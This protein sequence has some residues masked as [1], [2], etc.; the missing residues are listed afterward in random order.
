MKPNLP[1]SRAF[2]VATVVL[3]SAMPPAF[4]S[5]RAAET[6]KVV[7]SE[8]VAASSGGLRDIDGD[9]S[10]WIELANLGSRA[11][12]LD[13]WYLT[14][15]PERLPKWRIPAVEIEAGGFLVIFA[16]GK[17]RTDPRRELHASFRLDAGGGYLALVEPDGATIAHEMSP[18]Y[19]PQRAGFSYGFGIETLGGPIISKESTAR[20]HVPTSDALGTR[21]TG[22]REDEPFDDSA[23]AGWIEGSLAAGFDAG[24]AP[25]TPIIYYS[26]DDASDP[27]SSI[28]LSGHGFDGVVTT[29]REMS[30]QGADSKPRYT[31]EGGGRSGATTDRALD[32]GLRG[33]GGLVSVPLAA[34]GAFDSATRNDAVTISLWTFGSSDQPA[35]DVVFWGS[36]SSNGTGT[37]S[38]NAHV[39]WS[40]QVIYFDT[41][42]CCDGTQRISKPESDATRWRGEWNHYAF[43]KNGDEKEIWQNGELFATGTNTA[44][45]TPIRGFFIGGALN[46]GEWSYGGKIDDF[47]VWDRALNPV[48][49]ASLALGASPLALSSITP[50]VGTNLAQEMLGKRTSAYLRIPFEWPEAFGAGGAGNGGAGD[51]SSSGV[52]L[53]RM[54]YND[55][56]AAWI[57]GGELVRRN[58][59]DPLR[60]DSRSLAARP[61][62][63]SATFEDAILLAPREPE[64]RT[65]HVFAIHGLNQSAASPDFLVLPELRA[66]RLHPDLYLSPPTPGRPNGPGLA[67]FVADTKF[68]VDRGLFS[69]PFSVEITTATEGAEIYFTLD[70]S[71]PEPGSP[72]SD[73]YTGPIDVATTTTL[74]AKAFKN[75]LEPTDVD[76]QS[77][78]FPAEV[79][80]QPARPPGVPSTWSGG[81]RADY[82]V[83]PDIVEN[84][85]PGYSFEDALL[86]LPSV[87]IVMDPDDLFGPERGIYYHS[88]SRSERAGSFELFHPDGSDGFGINA[89]IRIHGYTSRDHNFTPKHSF[90]IVFKGEFGPTKLERDVFPDSSVARFDQ[91]VLRGMSTDS[92]PVTDGWP[93]PIPGVPRWFREKAQYLREQWM[94]DS[95]LAMG[96]LSCHGR[97][98]HVYLNGLYWGLY[99]LTERPTDSFLAEHLGGEREEYDVLKD[100]AELQSGEGNAWSELI[101]RA[102][103]G[104]ASAAPYQSIQGNNPDGTPNRN[105][106]NY[107][108]VDDHID[109]MIV[110][111]FAGADD[112]PNHNWW[113][114]RRRG[115]ESLG[116]KFFAWDQEISNIS[117]EQTQTSWGQRFEEV[118]APNSPAFLYARLRLNPEWRQRFVD[119][120]EKHLFAGG[121]LT[122]ENCDARW[123]ERAR[124]IDHAIV[125]ESARWGDARRAEPYRRE[126]EWLAEQNWMR[127][128]YWREN[129]AHAVE[130]FRR[131]GLYSAIDAPIFNQHG[132]EIE[133]G[134]E[135]SVTAARGTIYYAL[136]GD[137]PREP[138]GAV[139]AAAV[140]YA[141]PLTL[142]GTT[143]VK[144]RAF[145][146]GRWSGLVEALFH[147]DLPLRVTEIH[148]HPEDDPTESDFGAEDFEFL[149]VANTGR[150]PLDLRGVR[151]EG[152][153]DFDFSAAR[154]RTLAPS[155][156]AV[157]VRDPIAFSRQ[158][159]AT[160]LAAVIGTYSGKLDDAGERIRMVGPA[161]EVIQDFRYSDSWYPETDGFGPS[162]VIRDL[163]AGPATWGDEAGWQPSRFRGGSPGWDEN[164]DAG[165]SRLPSDIDRDGRVTITDAIGLLG[166]LFQGAN[167][168]LPC[169]S[170]FDAGGNQTILDANGDARVDLSDA[171]TILGYLFLGGPAPVLG[172]S[173][174]SIAGCSDDCGA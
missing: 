43:V 98:V 52:F 107:L 32:F 121:A 171:V 13:G 165:G 133:P 28:D 96:Q 132:G 160:G 86:S 122:P 137:D 22:A 106:P 130:R 54:K 69:E 147:F 73:L 159:D 136:G 153:V 143:L 111:I 37:R 145:D 2:L 11:V 63:L 36:S 109:Y 166:L 152:A 173:C 42:G 126:V 24:P 116:F 58:A 25:S 40:D 9:T 26:F 172:E 129:H 78:I 131:V 1:T 77:Y 118:S 101:S 34:R 84:T 53:L 149:E 117:L 170:D 155:E 44:D 51:P 55:G 14:D 90:R 169:G 48:E 105:L 140:E 135:L 6:A 18:A 108:D 93:S 7:L 64:S 103:A 61:Y 154:K 20:I 141:G 80:S 81:T 30:G 119:R 144:A 17:D 125:A 60:F 94:R 124:E 56:F 74:R 35:N 92:W 50:L 23:L 104:L 89:G 15:E 146:R 138:G 65:T 59:P 47:A 82:E 158:A 66:G 33:D 16:S 148:Y 128:T 151:I 4:F 19:P 57:D 46:N 156:L 91:L 31:R 163:Q 157:L 45:L 112:W 5:A 100:F 38:L 115:E 49:I 164:K 41:A 29:Q 88:A 27:N 139:S 67:G 110:H 99:L 127:S 72:G 142:R 8:I 3:G 102:S 123:M 97:F 162:L 167:Q 150:E 134:F 62:E 75:G 161:G 76:T 174:V 10:D 39:P 70:G 120:V 12:P 113:A 79:A 85:V 87:S 68:S 21:W 114:G 83:D 95:Q 168:E 71:E